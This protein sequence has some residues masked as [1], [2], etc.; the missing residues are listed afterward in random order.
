MAGEVT[1]EE[2]RMKQEAEEAAA[3]KKESD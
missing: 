2:I 3:A 1:D